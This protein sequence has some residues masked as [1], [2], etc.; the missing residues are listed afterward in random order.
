MEIEENPLLEAQVESHVTL[1]P[2]IE[3]LP[4]SCVE[5][6]SQFVGNLHN[7]ET[8]ALSYEYRYEQTKIQ[9]RL[10]HQ[11]LKDLVLYINNATDCMHERLDNMSDDIDP[12]ESEDMREM[13]WDL[14]RVANQVMRQA[15][16]IAFDY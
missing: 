1:R 8:A 6:I 2:N 11:S 13:I 5:L 10:H 15:D 16:T 12:D 3:D 7:A 14:E 4:I 9:A